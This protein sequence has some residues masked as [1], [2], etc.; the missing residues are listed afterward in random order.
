MASRPTEE[1][2]AEGHWISLT[3]G[4]SRRHVAS[5]VWIGSSMLNRG[6]AWMLDAQRARIG[7]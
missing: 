5:D 3:N 1:F 7:C 6:S 2:R 4:L